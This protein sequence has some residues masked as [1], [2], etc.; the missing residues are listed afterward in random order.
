MCLF[1]DKKVFSTQLINKYFAVTKDMYVKSCIFETIHP[2]S[3]LV[4]CCVSETR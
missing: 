2:I 3:I 1:H 4:I